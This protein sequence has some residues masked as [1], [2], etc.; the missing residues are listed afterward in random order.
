[1]KTLSAFDPRI[2]IYPD[3]PVHAFVSDNIYQIGAD[4]LWSRTDAGGQLVTGSGVVVAVIDTGVDYTHPDLGGG[5]GPAFKVLGGYDFWNGDSDPMDDNG[6]GSHVAGIIAANGI[7]FQGVAPD[8]RLLAYKALGAD[9]YGQMS[10]IIQAIDRALDP[11]QDGDTSDHADVISLSLG[12]AGEDSDP[13]CLAVENAIAA[14][15][16]VVVAA[17]NDGPAFGTVSSPGLAPD[18]IT[19]G[20]VDS[21][22]RLAEFSSRGT[23]MI[24]RV[25]PEI[26]A[27][28]VYITST[29]PYSNGYFSSPSGY[30]TLS[31]TSMATPH[32]SGAAALLLQLHPEWTPNQVKSALVS[33]AAVIQESLWSAGSGQLW[34][35]TAADATLFAAQPIVSYQFAGGSAQSVELQNSG[36]TSTF[37]TA[38]SDYSALLVNGSV[39]ERIWTNCSSV[40]PVAFSL[41]SGGAATVSLTVPLPPAQSPEGYYDGEI[42]VKDASR[43]LRIPF[44]FALLSKLSIHVLDMS[45]K[46]VFDSDGG[47]WAYSI[48]DVDISL[49][50]RGLGG[51]A[52]PASFL[53]TSGQYSVHAAGHQQIYLYTDPYILSYVVSLGRGET[54]EVFLNM[55]DARSFV[56]DLESDD[57]T[58][59]YAKN[60]RFYYRYEGEKNVSFHITSSDH[61]I[62]GSGIF[63]MPKSR[64]IYVSPTTVTIGISIA[65]YSYSAEM[66]D[67]MKLN[68]RHWFEFIKTTST[69]FLIDS[70]ADREYLL[71][72]EFDGVNASTPLSL[73]TIPGEYSTYQSKYDIPG[74]I[75]AVW[76]YGGNQLSM[77]GTSNFYIRR[78]TSSSINPLF[79]G[80]TRTA[81]VQGVQDE[82]YNYGSIYGAAFGREFFTADYVGLLDSCN[83]PGVYLPDRN[84]L[85]PTVVNVDGERIG[86]GPFYPAVRTMNTNDS[87][88]LVQPLLRDQSGAKVEGERASIPKMTMYRGGTQIGGYDL[89]EFLLRLNALRQIDLPGTGAYSARIQYTPGTQICDQVSI[90]LGFSVPS[91]DPNPPT[92]EAL[93]MPQRFSPGDTLD[94]HLLA[95]DASSITG[96]NISWKSS[97]SAAW[98]VLQVLDLGLGEYGASI[99][100][101]AADSAIYMKLRVTDSFGNYIEYSSSNASLAKIPVQFA[102]SLN[103]TE[104]QYRNMDASATV[105]GYLKDASGKPL[106]PTGAVPL[107]FMI[108][109][110]KVATI[111]DEFVTSSSHTHNGEVSFDWHFNP[112]TVFSG[113]NQVIDMRIDFDLGI[114][115]PISVTIPLTSVEVRND[116]PSIILRSP[117]NGSLIPSGQIILL[118]ITDD[119]SFVADAYLDGVLK[120]RLNAPWEVS[121]ATWAEGNHILEIVAVDD[122]QAS[123]SASFEFEID[124]MSPTIDVTY[125]KDGFRVPVGSEL[126][127]VI[128]DAHL[129]EASYAVDGGSSQLF[130]SP[131]S[132]DMTGWAVGNH[133]VVIVAKDLVNHTSSK[134]VRFEIVSNTIVIQLVSPSD[135]AAIRSSVPII[136]SVYGSSSFVLKWAEAGIWHDL[137]GQTYI[138]TTGW[139]QGIHNLVMNVT[140][141]QGGWDQISMRITIDDIAPVIQLQ[142]PSPN[143]FVSTSDHIVI[144]VQEGNLALVTWTL[145]GRTS[146][147][148]TSPISISL[149]SC[150]ADG[151][152]TL[153]VSAIDKAGN[154]AKAEFSF[155]MDST[156][157]SLFVTNLASG[158]AVRPGFVLNVSASDAYLSLVQWVLDNGQSQVLAAPYKIDT[159]HMALGWHTF[160]LV[161][162]D[163]SG[164]QTALNMSLYLDDAAPVVGELSPRNY[165]AGSDLVVTVRITDDFEVGGATLYYELHDGEYANVRMDPDNGSFA[166]VLP[167]SVLWDGMKVYVLG[168]DAAGN[169]A[170]SFRT[171]LRAAIA[172]S[173]SGGIGP[174]WNLLGSI[175]GIVFIS[176]VALISS[177]SF[178]FVAQRRNKDDEKTAEP[179]GGRASPQ[180][181]ASASS[182]AST[183][184]AMRNAREGGSKSIVGSSRPVAQV[185]ASAQRSKSSIPVLEVK[186]AQ[187][188]P[189]LLDSIPEILV[190]SQVARK[191]SDL[192]TDYGAMI[193]RELIIPSLK[194]SI[195]RDLNVE[196]DKQLAELVS[197]CEEP[198]RKTVLMPRP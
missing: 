185:N 145:W 109:E 36:Q 75:G 141:D 92:V 47:V 106:S 54:K 161:A 123:S 91:V 184:P 93:T 150:P 16:V 180:R 96:V 5:I 6:H 114:Y 194:T 72:W 19:V 118:E 97:Q 175:S 90:E 195:F 73:T 49:G 76:N 182:V 8:S 136:L 27:P 140:N 155:A 154:E 77:G 31:G 170:E 105:T 134:T 192:E 142:S 35:P 63:S 153:F 22:G 41:P 127:A 110:N 67:F 34:V 44:G 100:T 24:V 183:P 26:C 23:G 129:M 188:T 197:L 71:A 17:G 112:L 103:Q 102:L 68:W 111:L 158:D 51:A 7:S 156:P 176:S 58:P 3:L 108:G 149:A 82:V 79:S 61:S 45:G 132:I 84:T 60:Y 177:I 144:G 190:K 135:G 119:G 165:T 15:A 52:P 98:K 65:G 20:A 48:P 196:I 9:G 120:G 189:S 18:A 28:G 70:T 121:T 148:S 131:Y 157:P 125:P 33:S 83:G 88:R 181:I 56:L 66:W 160:Q 78:D 179:K 133:T 87:M 89:T 64:T 32:V 85:E 143:S 174:I 50:V 124:S 11:N 10:K 167:A 101:S 94:I 164:K 38:S 30:N 166:A 117:S 178:F 74:A 69:D 2:Q 130:A 14:G 126:I 162:K 104:F 46:E 128:S 29:V 37:S 137:G 53:V 25:K 138:S 116:L 42:H 113:P 186:K 191:D 152:F 59:I 55:S 39:C 146:S 151:S 40:T 13:V 62:T 1:V 43:D 95:R 163:A 107:E 80:L 99:Q 172:P 147:S 193:E 168:V 122:Q 159:L 115:E 4:Q 86:S 139:S 187:K 81:I 171:E 169:I 198:R 21:A 57:G 12:S 173:G